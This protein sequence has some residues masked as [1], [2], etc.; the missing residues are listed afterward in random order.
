MP[1]SAPASFTLDDSLLSWN[2]PAYEWLVK[3]GKESEWDGLATA[4]VVFNSDDRIL[5]LQRA[6]TDSMP[7]KWELPGG[8]VDD[9]DSTILHGAA[10]E[11]AEEAGLVAQHFGYVVTGGPGHDLG[12]AFP[13]STNTKVWCRFTFHVEVESCDSVKLDPKE[14]QDFAWVSE[15]EVKEQRTGDRELAITR[16]SVA[17]LIVEA[18]RLRR[19]Q[20]VSS[21]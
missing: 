11:L 17:A 8:A 20:M 16:D 2:I 7:N 4:N 21:C 13:N 12:H 15:Q 3:H 19:E 9:D 10:R 18:F 1:H 5:L 6:A 14:H